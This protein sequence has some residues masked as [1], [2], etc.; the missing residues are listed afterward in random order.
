MRS[1]SSEDNCTGDEYHYGCNPEVGSQSV[2]PLPEPDMVNETFP[3]AFNY[4]VDRIQLD[5][6][7]V[8]LRQYFRQPENGG[9]PEKKLYCHSD[10]LPHV[11][12]KYYYWRSEPW[13]AE[14]QNYRAEKIIKDL[15]RVQGDWWA[16]EDEHEE[17][18]NYKKRVE[19]K[20][21]KYLDNRE[22]ADT[23]VDFFEEEGVLQDRISG[24]V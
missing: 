23:E 1:E 3:V 8:L 13:K 11:A 6:G 10:N 14:E 18:Y 9:H 7:K 21:R 20:S 5:H 22:H 19:D 12:K 15:E 4:V 16:V 24:A 17:D 2:M